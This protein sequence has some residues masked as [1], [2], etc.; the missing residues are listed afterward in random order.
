M[1]IGSTA[2]KFGEHGH[3]D[4]AATKSGEYCCSLR[5]VRCLLG[6]RG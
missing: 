5:G 4:Y 3:A 2:G 6:R 1:L